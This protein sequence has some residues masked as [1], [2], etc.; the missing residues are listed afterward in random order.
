[1]GIAGTMSNILD[2][3]ATWAAAHPDATGA[4]AGTPGSFT[5]AG[6]RPPLDLAGL[7]GVTAS[8]ATMWTSGQYEALRDGT[9]AYW[10]GSGT[11]WQAGIAL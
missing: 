8:P 1:M 7:S 5:P 10:S 2:R 4:T 3:G 11:A 9:N 6:A